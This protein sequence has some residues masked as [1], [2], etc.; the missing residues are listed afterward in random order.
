MKTAVGAGIALS[1]L[2]YLFFA[3]HDAM[4]KL[5]VESTTVWQILF[6]RSIVILIGCFVLGGRSLARETMSSPTLRPM[7]LRSLFLLA[8]WLCYFNAAKHLPL[9]DLTTLYFAAPIAAILLAIPI[10]GEK[11]PLTSWIAVI[12]GF[13]GVVIASNPTG[14]STGWPV[15]LALVAAVCWA[16]A[17]TLLRTTSQNASSMVQM[18]MTN[19][20][21][22][23]LTA[24]M[25]LASWTMPGG[26][27]QILLLAVGVIGGLGQLSYFE[28]LRRAPISVIAPLE[29]TALIWAF[30]LGYAIWKDVPG[31]NVWAGAV[32]IAAA[33]L[34]VLVAQ[35][36]RRAA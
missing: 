23:A 36:R 30:A 4:I 33:G 11:V 17:T 8:A 27:S 21:F 29:Y 3:T 14:I 9:A 13:V 7:M 24:P 15:Y 20:F 6:C 5:L 1:S 28:A 18:A 32:L 22:L 2:A 34:I 10:L 12:T 19:V 26:A 31:P 35:G 16:I 25:A